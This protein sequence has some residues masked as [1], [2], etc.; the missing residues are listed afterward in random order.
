MLL[1]LV[2]AT[3]S[4]SGCVFA[5]SAG[6]KISI[7]VVGATSIK[8]SCQASFDPARSCHTV[9]VKVNNGGKF[10]ASIFSLD[11]QAKVDDGS[12]VQA[13][14]TEGPDTVAAG[15]EVQTKVKFTTDS[16]RLLTRIR[17][18]TTSGSAVE[19]SVPPYARA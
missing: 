18:L 11:W 2:L 16:G 7:A 10:E 3:A 4:L 1:V 9:T 6:E 19:V 8:G 13:D 17:Y 14:Q 15:G 5:G 12:D